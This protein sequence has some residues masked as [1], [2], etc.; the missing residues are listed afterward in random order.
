MFCPNCGTQVQNGVS[1]CPNCGAG[2][3]Q[4][5]GQQY[6]AP[7]QQPQYQQPQQPQYQQPQYQQTPQQPY[8]QPMQYNQM[9][10]DNGKVGL[11]GILFFLFPLIG[12][13]MYFIWRKTKP[14]KAGKAIKIALFGFI[15]GMATQALWA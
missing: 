5:Q 9:P 14:L 15:V 2:M 12:L 7:P 6:A 4:G 10:M 11:V 1:F 13:I 8:Q 3:A